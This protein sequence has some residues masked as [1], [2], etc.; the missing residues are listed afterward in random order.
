[1]SPSYGTKPAEYISYT[2]DNGAYN[3]FNKEDFS[4]LLIKSLQW[5]KPLWI[6]VPDVV[7]DAEATFV[8]WH[9]WHRRVAPFG[10]LAFACQDGMEPSDVPPESYCCFI[11]GT[12]RWKLRN[13]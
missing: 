2:I 8:K 13:A 9:Y 5:H 10:K 4:K 3:G 11:G 12:T 7:G 6:V 1:M